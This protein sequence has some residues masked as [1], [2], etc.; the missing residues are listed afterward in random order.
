LAPKS[1][2]LE[3][4]HCY[5]FKFS[6]EC[7]R[8]VDRGTEGAEGGGVLGGGVSPP[9]PTRGYGEHRKLPQRGPGRSP[10]RQRILGIFQGLRCLLVETMRYGVQIG[11]RILYGNF[12]SV[13]KGAPLNSAALFGRTRRTCPRIGVFHTSQ[14]ETLR[15][16]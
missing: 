2:T 10:G 14:V 11:Q 12:F 1:M 8:R 7:P 15:S 6:S 9:Q 13:Q 5:K 4:L 3:D 16:Q